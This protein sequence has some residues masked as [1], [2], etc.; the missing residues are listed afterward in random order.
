MN[1][2]IGNAFLP[3]IGGAIAFITRYLY[4]YSWRLRL[5]VRELSQIRDAMPPAIFWCR[6]DVLAL[7][8]LMDILHHYYRI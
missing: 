5:F 7:E 6:T 2:L 8:M 4:P 3:L 1:I